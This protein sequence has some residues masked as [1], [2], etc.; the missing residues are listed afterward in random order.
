MKIISLRML[1]PNINLKPHIV[2]R[3]NYFYYDTSRYTFET[4]DTAHRYK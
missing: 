2:C 3:S 4:T 1:K